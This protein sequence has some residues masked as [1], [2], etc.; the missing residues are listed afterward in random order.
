MSEGGQR[1]TSHRNQYVNKYSNS[2]DLGNFC[3]DL[4][5]REDL[6]SPQPAIRK[7]R[8]KT[9]VNLTTFNPNYVFCIHENASLMKVANQGLFALA[10]SGKCT[11]NP[12][13]S[14]DFVKMCGGKLGKREV[15]TLGTAR[16]GT[17]RSGGKVGPCENIL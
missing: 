10:N 8:F 7:I 3:A 9:T 15:F 5:P 14:L 17:P 6:Q 1:S 16:G 11:K 4:N 13:I 12:L 2:E